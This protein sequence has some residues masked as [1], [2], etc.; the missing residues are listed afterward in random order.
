MRL[1][2]RKAGLFNFIQAMGGHID[3]KALDEY[4]EFSLSS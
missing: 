2:T 3:M 4:D 1:Q